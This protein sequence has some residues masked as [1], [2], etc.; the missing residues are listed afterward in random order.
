MHN[1]NAAK[2]QQSSWTPPKVK[3]HA[4]KDRV[5]MRAL[6]AEEPPLLYQPMPP[7]EPRPKHLRADSGDLVVDPD[8]DRVR[9]T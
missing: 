7:P 8:E 1:S 5:S 9:K 4:S 6:G 2:T 3:V